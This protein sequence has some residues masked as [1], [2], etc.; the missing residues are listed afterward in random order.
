MNRIVLKARF[1]GSLLKRHD[2][3]VLFVLPF[4]IRRSYLGSGVVLRTF[5]CLSSLV[6]R[7]FEFASNYV[8]SH[9]E[10]DVTSNRFVRERSL[11]REFDRNLSRDDFSV[12]G[13]V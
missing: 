5:S 9:R 4:F 6:Q 10:F 12:I 8:M 13:Q 7:K 2:S 1:G 11:A 3:R